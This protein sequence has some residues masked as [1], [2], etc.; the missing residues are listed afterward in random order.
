LSF[1]VVVE[2]VGIMLSGSSV[3]ANK[4]LFDT[5]RHFKIWFSLDPNEFLDFENQL[6]FI[7]AI[8]NNPTAKF[9]LIYSSKLLNEN[10]RKQLLAFSK[11]YGIF[12]QDFDTDI[13]Q[14]AENENDKKLYEL[15]KLEIEH[16]IK[17]QGGNLAAAS[18]LVRVMIPVLEKF[19]I[20]T[21]F[22]REV[23][24]LPKGKLAVCQMPILFTIVTNIQK[25]SIEVGNDRIAVAVNP[26]DISKLSQDA[27]IRMKKLQQAIIE[28]YQCAKKALLSTKHKGFSAA[29]EKELPIVLAIGKKYFESYPD[30]TIFEL[31][32]FITKLSF[33][34]IKKMMHDDI[35]LFEEQMR[36]MR[37]SVG[38]CVD[39]LNNEELEVINELCIEVIK[40]QFLK[41]S[42]MSISGPGM[43]SVLY[44]DLIPETLYDEKGE[45]TEQCSDY[46]I[47]QG[48]VSYELNMRK[49][50]AIPSSVESTGS[51]T[52]RP[53]ESHL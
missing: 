32:R 38:L 48:R 49:P 3:P 52:D 15:A 1:V 40:T 13:L 9:T 18:D 5:S 36:A 35:K 12:L 31:R 47:A 17:K 23:H 29:L 41:R 37:K 21:D 26:K 22:E 24:S 50:L 20:Y 10:A 43:C 42:V 7:R 39:N 30:A 45:P 11:Q 44:G 53:I 8:T 25:R 28:N 14:L 16:A 33:K 2:D 6:L 46:I 51:F 27:V 34:S 19:G 4:W